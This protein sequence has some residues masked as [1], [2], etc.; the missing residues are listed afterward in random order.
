MTG[1]LE[2]VLRRRG[3]LP[4]LI[5]FLWACAVLP[6]LMVRSFIWEEGTNAEIARDVLSRGHF[7]EPFIYSARWALKPSLDAWLIAGVAT[8]TGGVNEWSARLPAM[9]SILLTAL[10]V[11]RVTRRYASLNASLFAALSSLFCPMLLQKLTI[12]EPDTIVTL[13]SFGAFV[14]W[15]NGEA[16]GRTTIARWIGCGC[17]LAALAMAKGPQPAGYF[18]IGVGAYLLLGHRWREL[19]G[20]FIC[21][22]LPAAAII[23]WGA[24]V[25]RPGDEAMWLGY[26]RLSSVPP[27]SLYITGIVRILIS[28]F[29]ELL[30]AVVVLPFTPWPWPREGTS[31]DVPPIVAPLLLYSGLCTAALI[32]WPGALSRYAMPIVPS[33]AVLAGIAWDA[34]EE[35]KYSILRRLTGALLCLF[36]IYQF[37][38]VVVIMPLFFDRFGASRIAGQA[39]E[40]AIRAAPAPAFCTGLD[41]NQLFYMRE[42][43]R[44]ID[45]PGM[46][47]IMPPAWLI[48]P[49]DQFPGFVRLRPDLDVGVVIETTS[50]PNLLAA[51]LDMR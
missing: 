17:L 13:L 19:P 8:F 41:T 32:L 46:A 18:V 30:P 27:L 43:I 38:L 40:R 12:A 20:F 15:W 11:Q 37:V 16:S 4:L 9:I 35:S 36:L 34:L 26:A 7:L 51:H 23:A 49:S 14:L 3:A 2:L 1:R 28:L 44:C 48:I 10:L 45:L 5:V 22:T 21:I 33:V 24:A 31:A 50:G 42:P 29:L 25:Y 39:I 47:S 6:N